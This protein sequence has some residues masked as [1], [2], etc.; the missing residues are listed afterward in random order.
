MNDGKLKCDFCSTPLREPV[1]FGCRSFSFQFGPII[2]NMNGDWAGCSMC[3]TLVYAERWD[4]LLERSLNT[5][6]STPEAV[7]VL[8]RYVALLHGKFRENRT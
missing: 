7:P 4:E 5:C 2:F 8:R 3:S 6:A 1:R